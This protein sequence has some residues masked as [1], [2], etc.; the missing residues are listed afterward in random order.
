MNSVR[1]IYSADAATAGGVTGTIVAKNEKVVLT[2]AAGANLIAFGFGAGWDVSGQIGTAY[3]LDLFAIC[4]QGNGKMLAGDINQSVLYY[5]NKTLPGLKHGG[6][7]LTGQGAGDD[8]RITFDGSAI[9]ANV[10]SIIV[11]INI[12]EATQRNQ[13]FGNVKNAYGRIFDTAS[14]D[15]DVKRYNLSEDYAQFT[16]VTVC[17]IYRH[18]GGWKMEALGIGGNGDITALCAPYKG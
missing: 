12:Y 8:E 10:E 14:A 6:D 13:H 7:N 9:P 16:A 4:L 5:S 17:R 18:E 1:K 15:T 3:D 11:G 2:N